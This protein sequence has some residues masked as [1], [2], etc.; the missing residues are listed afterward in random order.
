MCNL[1]RGGTPSMVLGNHPSDAA[2][3]TAI[4]DGN[5][6]DDANDDDGDV[7]PMRRA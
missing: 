4:E 2:C 1:G 3:R 6:D 5:D 7:Y